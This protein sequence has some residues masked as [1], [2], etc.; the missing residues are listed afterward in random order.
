MIRA[1]SQVSAELSIG[2][3]LWAS[4]GDIAL[5]Q[6]ALASAARKAAA[7]QL[8]NGELEDLNLELHAA[9]IAIAAAATSIDGFAAAV[10]SCNL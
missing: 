2:T 8:A 9:M 10:Q 5:E 1:T 3:E 4:W 6:Q 7:A